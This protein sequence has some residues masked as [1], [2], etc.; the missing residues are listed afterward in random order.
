MQ[1][2]S[3]S[4]S[5]W[6]LSSGSSTEHAYHLYGSILDDY[7][8]YDRHAQRGDRVDQTWT[9]WTAF[10]TNA[11]WV[12]HLE[13]EITVSG[14]FF[15]FIFFYGEKSKREWRGWRNSGTMHGVFL[16]CA[17][18]KRIRN[19]M[20]SHRAPF[21]VA[22]SK[23]SKKKKIAPLFLRICAGYLVCLD[24]QTTPNI[25]SNSK[26]RLVWQD[27]WQFEYQHW[28][29]F[30]LYTL[31]F[32]T[33]SLLLCGMLCA[34]LGV[35]K[36]KEKSS[37]VASFLY[38]P[39]KKQKLDLL[40]PCTTYPHP[41]CSQ[42]K[43]KI[44]MHKNRCT[45]HQRAKKIHR[46]ATYRHHIV[47]GIH[48]THRRSHL[49]YLKKI[50]QLIFC[51]IFS[52]AGKGGLFVFGDPLC[53]HA[54]NISFLFLLIFYFFILHLSK[55]KNEKKRGRQQPYRYGSM[56]GFDH[57]HHIDDQCRALKKNRN[58]RFSLFFLFV[59][60]QFFPE[61]ER[62]HH[63]FLFFPRH[64]FPIFSKKNCSLCVW[65]G[66]DFKYFCPSCAPMQAKRF[67]Q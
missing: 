48:A 8:R 32:K 45:N 65:G 26:P 1:A 53:T 25:A 47:F 13:F 37:S 22:K 41:T 31:F 57:G 49:W 52:S 12:Y 62:E 14:F 58:F 28:F 18:R 59:D 24:H 3:P 61:G 39:K 33:T 36:K 64:S 51:L 27:C 30:Y 7:Y 10:P 56:P 20:F 21:S 4:T 11:G 46:N 63:C 43:I 42:N 29:F 55:K 35:Q 67:W 40:L 54:K 15:S 19:E 2:Y 6:S 50:L 23:T 16:A 17:T 60:L 5:T 34:I 66:D 9:N 44:K 38:G